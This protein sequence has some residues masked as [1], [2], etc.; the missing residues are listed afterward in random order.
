MESAILGGAPL[1]RVFPARQHG[2]E[3]FLLCSGA[4]MGCV[5][6]PYLLSLVNGAPD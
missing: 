1:G 5:W 4:G 2:F 6:T 3:I